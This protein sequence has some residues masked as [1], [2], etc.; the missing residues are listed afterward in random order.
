MKEAPIVRTLPDGGKIWDHAFET[1]AAKVYVP[2]H[3][4]RDDVLN[5]GFISPYLLVFA[6]ADYSDEEAVNFAK[7]NG[8][9]E[10]AIEFGTSVVFIYP[11]SGN[12]WEDASGDIL[13]EI[14]TNSRI[15][16][17]YQ[18]GYVKAFNR[19]T[20]QIDGYFIRGAIFRCCLF[21]FGKSADYIATNCI[22]HFEGDGLWGKADCA[23]VLCVLKNLSV[24]PVIEASDIPIASI[25]NEEDFDA[26]IHEKAEH[27]LFTEEADCMDVIMEFGKNFRRMVGQLE[28][29]PD[30]ARDGMKI[31]PSIATVATSK[32]NCGDDAGTEKHEIGY[33]AFYNEGLF[34]K[35]P[36]PLLLA[37]HGGGDSAFYIAYMSGWAKIAHRH[38][39][40]LVSIENH[41]NSTA[42][43]MQELIASL[44]EKYNIDAGR[45]YASGFSMGGC[46]TWDMIQEYPDILAAAAP[47]DATFEVG[48][49]S[50][51]QPAA[52]EI[53][54]DVLVPIYYT[55]GEITPL[56][57]LPFQALKCHDRMKYVFEINDIQKP[58][59]VA[60]ERQE[61]WENKIWG[62][63]GDKTVSYYDESRKGT[64]T[65]QFFESKNGK[66]YTVF[67][68]ISEQ[69]H[70]CREHTCEYAWR[71]MSKFRRN[72]K[73]DIEGE[74]DLCLEKDSII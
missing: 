64:L 6:E 15:H 26:V 38:D 61:E 46:K 40:L 32:D 39:F 74:I 34:E 69:G 45:I 5:Y 35:G 24:E 14:Y 50:Y 48:L 36:A 27:T 25:G 47:M 57:E 37:F 55:G 63:N 67:G 49:N 13:S 9:E 70:E 11:T 43:E 3:E 73:K 23:P 2:K 22:R 42:T 21:G 59:D 71:F 41:L 30:L 65:L 68:S 17:Y 20:K 29:D 16:Q 31:E 19:F 60:F 4:L 1:F 33:V 56:P 62:I 51:G 8:F 72:D 28:I 10:T 12:G 18:D 44:Q 66:C 58:Y 53:N 52:C 54:R 7:E